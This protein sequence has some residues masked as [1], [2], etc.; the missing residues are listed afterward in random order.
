MK[1]PLPYLL[2]YFLSIIACTTVKKPQPTIPAPPLTSAIE[3]PKMVL[4]GEMELHYIEQGTGETLILLHG[5]Q[6]DY[7][8]WPKQIEA[9]AS[10]YRVIS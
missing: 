2:F 6:G 10:Q 1:S 5:G 4:V 7:R 9:F 8:A 3:K